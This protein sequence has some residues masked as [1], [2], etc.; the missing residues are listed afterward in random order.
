M[1]PVADS[2]DDADSV[3]ANAVYDAAVEMHA[4]VAAFDAAL[5]ADAAAAALLAVR[6]RLDDIGV[7]GPAATFLLASSVDDLRLVATAVLGDGFHWCLLV[8]SE[9]AGRRELLQRSRSLPSASALGILVVGG[10]PPTLNDNGLGTVIGG[11]PSVSVPTLT[12]RLYR[13]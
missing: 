3:A 12:P 8:A 13:A 5:A 4:D 11:Q 2:S 9:F 1:C 10:A 7:V 6:R